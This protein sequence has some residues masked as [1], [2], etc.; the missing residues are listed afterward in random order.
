MNLE[1]FRILY[2]HSLI[3]ITAINNSNLLLG[4]TID[5]LLMNKIDIDEDSNLLI[6]GNCQEQFEN[7]KD[8][9]SE[10]SERNRIYNTII[11]DQHHSLVNPYLSP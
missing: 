1:E 5:L 4:F 6:M 2:Y 11:T 8:D 7:I 3:I 9:F 10:V